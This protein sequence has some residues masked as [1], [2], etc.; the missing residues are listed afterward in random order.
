MRLTLHIG[1][2]KTG[3]T[4]IQRFM[5]VNR[6]GL[7]EHGILVP[8]SPGKINQRKLPVIAYNPDRTDEFIKQQKLNGPVVRSEAI[9]RW[10]DEFREEVAH[11]N[12]QRVLVS[13]EHFQSRLR[14]REEIERLHGLLSSVFDQIDVV[15]YLR[16]P[17]QTAVS[18][19]STAVRSGANMTEVPGP[20]NEYFRNIVNHRETIQVWSEIFG[21]QNMRLRLFEKGCFHN[22]NL[23]DDFIHASELPAMEYAFPPPQNESLSN[24]GI[25]VL[26]RINAR[27][28]ERV[29]SNTPDPRY[30]RISSVLCNIFTKGAAHVPAPE[31]IQAYRAAFAES[32]EWVRQTYFPN[33]ER[34]FHDPDYEAKARPVQL[35]EAE[36]QALCDVIETLAGK[37]PA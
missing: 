15:L 24:L 31:L 4:T 17:V 29:A 30:E 36:L 27:H 18:L 7:A 16:E 6:V 32:N 10:W 12:G 28:L 3:T 37:P 19:F 23:L 14:S 21:A 35:P 5:Y 26:S 13:S 2:E 9:K 33:R 1:T 34:L 11:F 20:Q 25:G 22:G 8:M